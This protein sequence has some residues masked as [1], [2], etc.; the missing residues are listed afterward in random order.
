MSNPFSRV[1]RTNFPDIDVEVRSLYEAN[2]VRFLKWLHMQKSIKSWEYEPERFSF[3]PDATGN[4]HYTPDFKLTRADGSHYVEVKGYMHASSLTKL[5]RFKKHFPKLF[6]EMIFVFIRKNCSAE[7]RL[8]AR[9]K[10]HVTRNEIW[11]LEDIQ[12]SVGNII[13][14]ETTKDYDNRVM[15]QKAEVYTD[16]PF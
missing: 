3:K 12:K 9:F 7:K 14:Y 16:V 5:A 1:R 13:G 2:T 4:W 6:Y 8:R 10:S 15:I 11:Y